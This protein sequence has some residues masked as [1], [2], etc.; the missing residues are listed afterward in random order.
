MLKIE[1]IENLVD[2]EDIVDLKGHG[3]FEDFEYLEDFQKKK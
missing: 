3:I 2:L 1:Y